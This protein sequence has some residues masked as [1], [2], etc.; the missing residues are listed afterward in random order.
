MHKKKFFLEEPIESIHQQIPVL[1]MNH[2]ISILNKN[3]AQNN[4]QDSSFGIYYDQEGNQYGPTDFDVEQENI[5]ILDNAKNKVSKVSS[6]EGRMDA[7]VRLESPS[8]ICE[9][10]GNIYILDIANGQIEIIGVNGSSKIKDIDLG[11]NEAISEFEVVNGC[12]YIT[13]FDDTEHTIQYMDQGKRFVAVNN[14]IG[15]ISNEYIYTF[16][17]EKNSENAYNGTMTVSNL[18]NEL[19]ANLKII[20]NYPLYGAKLLGVNEKGNFLVSKTVNINGKSTSILDEIDPNSNI[21][22]EEEAITH[23]D[24]LEPFIFDNGKIYNAKENQEVLKIVATTVEGQPE[25]IDKKSGIEISPEVVPSPVQASISRSQ[26]MNIA[27]SYHTSFSWKCTSRNISAMRGYSKPSYINGA[28]TYTCM[29]YCWGGF[30]TKESFI[31]GLKNGGRAGNINTRSGKVGNTFGLD[32]SGYVSRCWGLTSKRGTTTIENV[33]RRISYSSLQPGD[34]LN[35][36]EEHVMLFE[37][38]DSNGDY[39]LYEATKLNGY[40]RVSHTIR[41]KSKVESQYKA[42]RYNGI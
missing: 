42:I 24:M 18:N 36:P 16:A 32:C 38:R 2:A 29:P 10:K 34:A 3:N 28:G 21:I 23:A 13:L 39:V 31:R 15:R 25:T 37:K 17:L 6:T 41:S 20:S 4:R 8:M 30:D 11:K 40:D 19:L 12:I 9:D 1:H 22:N 35:Y 7:S 27:R 5:F 14:F 26:I 33:A